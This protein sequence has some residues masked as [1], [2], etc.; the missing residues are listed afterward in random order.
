[1]GTCQ[2]SNFENVRQ[3]VTDH[4]MKA[5]QAMIKNNT[6][7]VVLFEVDGEEVIIYKTKGNFYMISASGNNV[8]KCIICDTLSY[9]IYYTCKLRIN[10]KFKHIWFNGEEFNSVFKLIN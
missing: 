2:S 3:N 7:D 9:E 10:G 6:N 5:V 1:M 8:T 4:G